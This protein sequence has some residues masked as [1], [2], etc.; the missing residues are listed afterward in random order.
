[1]IKDKYA[2]Y[3]NDLLILLKLRHMD[4]SEAFGIQEQFYK[5]YIEDFNDKY[6]NHTYLR[7]PL[8]RIG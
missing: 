1:M 6:D 4:Q 8:N 2:L 5:K 3:E 7:I